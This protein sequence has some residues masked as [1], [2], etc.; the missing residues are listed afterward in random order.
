MTI[1]QR[2]AREQLQAIEEFSQGL[3]EVVSS[4][5]GAT[6]S[7]DVDISISCRGIE[8]RGSGL[9]YNPRER[10]NLRI[11]GQFPFVPPIVE[12]THTRFAGFPHV[13]WRRQ[14]CLYLAPAVEWNV[15]DGMFGF[16]ERLLEW[17]RAA[18]VDE[19]DP[20][21]APQ[22]P[23]VAYPSGPYCAA[24][25]HRNTPPI[26][27]GGWV[28]TVRLEVHSES[29]VDLQEWTS[30]ESSERPNPLAAAILLDEP[31][32]FEFPTTLKGLTDELQRRQVSFRLFI[33]CLIHAAGLNPAGQ[34][35]FAVI[36]TPMRGERGTTDLK[37]HLAVWRIPSA[38]ADSLRAILAGT[39]RG[40]D[41]EIDK[42]VQWT[43]TASVEWCHVMEDRP[44]VVLGRDT[45]TPLAWC[46]DRTVAIWGCG[47]LG[48]PIA[49]WVARA[50]CRKLI[51]WDKS[52]VQPG[53]LV[54]QPFDYQDIGTPKATA[55]ATHLRAIRPEL[56]IEEH[57]GDVMLGPLGGDWT[58][59]ADLLIDATASEPVL[60]LLEDRRR[61]T[62][63]R[64]PA[65]SMA[66]DA[67]A[68]RGFVVVAPAAFSG[69]PREVTRL[70]KI[71]ACG[72]EWARSFVD[73]FWR[74][75]SSDLLRPE[76][77]CSEPTFVGSAADT[78]ALAAAM[79]NSAL[80]RL[81]AS[82]TEA[83]ASFVTQ[84][85]AAT[86]TSDRLAATWSWPAARVVDDMRGGYEVRISQ[87]AWKEMLAWIAQSRRRNGPSVETGGVLF[88]ERNDSLR[89]LW[90]D[91]V[92][93]P[94]PDS[95]QSAS[96]FV[97]G[98]SGTQ[99]INEEKRHRT[100][101][102]VACVGLWHTHP[103]MN[104]EPS[105]RDLDGMRRT[106]TTTNPSTPRSLMLILG[107]NLGAPAA[108]AFTFT[109]QEFAPPNI[110]TP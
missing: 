50:G 38:I 17:L 109:R 67:L 18:A 84:P 36:G 48:A 47:A 72:K 39:T 9:R 108:G 52:H 66:I 70:A 54:R 16:V 43:T 76:P 10:F 46:R 14:L 89:I 2:L 80:N 44:E 85:W 86:R 24:V 104:A 55:L 62:S 75:S 28:G 57:C 90:V 59:Q 12:T 63:V 6:G 1:G 74:R 31:M 53:L 3:L 51:L 98:V 37:Q 110:P 101:N 23:P 33:L 25:I 91:E 41:D 103:G 64:I 106:V 92:S 26:S 96:E 13:Q 15:G 49:E 60:Q 79:L 88:G 81:A 56:V 95:I 94:P 107:G 40:S 93:G 30:I 68:R 27:V 73:A 71:E 82:S 5:V 65:I 45:D 61:A 42:V 69:G 99:E 83:A 77:G 102:S 32:P 21:G 7:L 78:A 19:L 8:H 11:P 35:V 20:I 100:L 22:H 34:P 29:R 58:A 87:P 4:I 97:C 105:A